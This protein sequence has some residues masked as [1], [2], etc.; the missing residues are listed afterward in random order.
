MELNAK[1]LLQVLKEKG[2]DTLYHANTV[3]TA[4][5]FLHQGHLMA[6]GIVDERGLAQTPQQTDDLDKRYGIWY[7]LFL[8]GV[9]IHDRTRRR[10]YY[11]PVLFEF[12]IGLLSQDWLPSLW[13][14]KS[15][16]QNW[17][18][19]DK[20]ADRWFATVDEFSTNYQK[21]NFDKMFVLR[22]VGG[23]LRLQPFLRKIVIDNPNQTIRGVDAY[24]QAVGA[25]RASARVAGLADT[26]IEARV[27]RDGCKCV[28]L[29]DEMYAQTLE[30]FFAP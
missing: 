12:D 6:R 27:C 5:A 22:H 13:V 9:D 19:E 1:A 29:Y 11:G 24:S 16:P 28:E 7:D 4:C 17:K 25:L 30:N 2:V 20:A 14:T 26:H 18:D 23:L 21:G 10:N 15:N 8:D 3:Q